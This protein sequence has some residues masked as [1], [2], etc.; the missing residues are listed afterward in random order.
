[1]QD[2]IHSL[3][4]PVSYD[5]AVSKIELRETHISWVFLTGRF[6]YKIKKPVDFGFLNFTTLEKRKFYCEEEV[7]LNRRLAPDIY[8]SVVPITNKDNHPFISR[9]ALPGAEILDYAVCM[10]QFEPDL[11]LDRIESNEGLSGE[12]VDII[13]ETVADFHSRVERAALESAFGWPDQVIGPPRDN[14][15]DTHVQGFE[16]RL[17]QIAEW[18]EKEWARL[19]PVFEKRKRNGFIRE[20]HGDMHLGNIAL[21]NDKPVIFDCIEFNEPFRWID[22]QSDAAFLVMDLVERGHKDHAFRF[23]NRYLECTGDYEGLLVLRY[24]L[25]YR[26]MVRAKVASLRMHQEGANVPELVLS[27]EHYVQMAE[28]FANSRNPAVILTCGL[29]GSGKTRASREF[30]ARGMIRVRSDVERKRIFALAP[31]EK[32]GS[33]LDQGIYTQ[34][35]GKKTYDRLLYVMRVILE[36]GYP[37]IVDATFLE[38]SMRAPFFAFALELKIP[39]VV[40]HCHAE[41]DVLR[42][43]VIRRMAKGKDASEADLNVLESQLKKGYGFSDAEKKSLVEIDTGNEE[44]R[45]RAVQEVLRRAG[46]LE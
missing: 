30:L 44:D 18:T 38:E 23:L 9:V 17:G 37:A 46:A 39:L 35:A 7:R 15:K 4:D 25:V 10:A 14:F 19:G 12:Q 21:V 3:Q 16:T 28:S 32:S 22:V 20:C 33:A 41:P 40:A 45:A 42:E 8:L 13:A 43:R 11:T 6:A 34:D 36:S 26:A 2:W 1:M 31:E 29:S 27:F 24:Y 5:H